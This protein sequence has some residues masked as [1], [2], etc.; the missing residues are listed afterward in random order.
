MRDFGFNNM[1][2][3]EF[4]KEFMR[5]LN[6]YQASLEGF[7][8]KNYNSKNFMNNPF[9]N[10]L[11][12]DDQELKNILKNI[13]D[14][15]NVER[16]EDDNGEWEKHSWQSPDGSSSFSSYTRNSFYNPFDGSVKFKEDPEEIDTL[17]LLKRKLNKAI[18]E[19][20]YENAAKIRDL[21]N[22]LKEDDNG[23][24]VTKK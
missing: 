23:K 8:K 10:I 22:S 9:F 16:G 19:E 15:L 2:D 4:R 12:I 3:D 14:N 24:D 17:K 13:E 18:D 7:M 11:P 21:I 5:F 20:N 1:N 6:T